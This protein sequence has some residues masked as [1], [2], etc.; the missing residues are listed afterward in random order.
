MLGRNLRTAITGRF[1]ATALFDVA[2]ALQ[3]RIAR[4]VQK[5]DTVGIVQRVAMRTA[6]EQ[7]IVMQRGR[8]ENAP[9]LARGTGITPG[10]AHRSSRQG[11]A[12]QRAAAEQ[13]QR[14][15]CNSCAIAEPKETKGRFY[16][17]QLHGVREIDTI[18]FRSGRF[19]PSIVHGAVNFFTR[20]RKYDD[21]DRSC[22][23][24]RGDKR[25]RRLPAEAQCV[26]IRIAIAVD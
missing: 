13:V 21:A 2:I 3:C 10:A 20:P 16:R 23:G 26:A 19:R 8:H 11:A 1:G 15:G 6:R 18:A 7:P 24:T 9:H 14:P 25:L 12:R 4:V 17:Q 5:D 22:F